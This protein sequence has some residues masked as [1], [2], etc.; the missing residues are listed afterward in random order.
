MILFFTAKTT[1]FD[2]KIFRFYSAFLKDMT[3]RPAPVRDD[4]SDVIVENS[5]VY[6]GGDAAMP[7]VMASV[8]VMALAAVLFVMKKKQA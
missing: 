2:H 5:A 6:S 3:N 8:A 1:A 7:V 4:G